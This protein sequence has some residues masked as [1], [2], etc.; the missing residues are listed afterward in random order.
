MFLAVQFMEP[1]YHLAFHYSRLL[2]LPAIGTVLGIMA[3]YL[4]GRLDAFIMRITDIAMS[5]PSLL[6]AIIIAVSL[7]PGFFTV[8][9]ALSIL[10][11]AG[12]ARIIRGEALRLR[13]S[14]FVSQALISGASP[15]ANYGKTYFPQYR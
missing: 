12:Y 4:G 11:W 9:F 3:G 14:D 15:A 2:L 6:L 7:G 5:F 1:E 13:N 10:G 8:I